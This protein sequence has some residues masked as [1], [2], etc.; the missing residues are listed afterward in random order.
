MSQI[1][2]LEL[3]EELALRAKEIAV[4]TDRRLED[5]LIEWLDQAIA[6]PPIETLSD[7][8]F[9]ALCDLQMEAAQNEE[10]SLLLAQNR[11][12]QLNENKQRR[13]DELMQT[14]RRGLVRKAQAIKVAVDRHLRPPLSD[15]KTKMTATF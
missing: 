7:E 1:V 8:Q 9:L 4:R 13:L 12:G 3:P 11:E 10:L 14:Y 15:Q 2:M 6:E 5:V